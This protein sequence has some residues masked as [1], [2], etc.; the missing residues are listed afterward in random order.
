MVF[1]L[2]QKKRPLMPCTERRARLL[3]QRG[4]AV[5]HRFRPFTIRLKDRL[6][7]DS[8]LQPVVLKIDPGSQTTGM[9]IVREEETPEGKVHHVLHFSELRHK[10]DLVAERMRKRAAYRRRRRTHNLR[11]R[12]PRFN[13]RCRPVGWLTP[14][15]RSRVGNVLSWVKRYAQWVPMVRIDLEY[16]KFD[17][18][19]LQN[20]EISGVAYQQGELAGYEVR[21]YLL[22]KWGR[23][24][25]YC[26]AEGGAADRGPY[27]PEEPWRF[28]PGQQFG[29]GLP[30]LQ[31]SEGPTDGRRVW[32]SRGA[33]AGPGTAAG[34]RGGECGP[35]VY[36]ARVTCPGVYSDLL[37]RGPDEV[38]PDPVRAAENPCP[39]RP[40]CGRGGEGLWGPSAGSAD[41]WDR[42]RGPVSHECR[43]A[44]VPPGVSDALQ[45]GAGISDGRCGMGRGAA[46]EACWDVCRA[47]DGATEWFLSDWED[48]WHFLEILPIVAA[49]RWVRIR[50][51][52]RT[53]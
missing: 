47:G 31:L 36:P 52:K 43:C 40:V 42:T 22:E 30:S 48:R 51:E 17:T 4:R 32:P 28:R 16:T 10:G 12:P 24:C 44:W 25:A 19:K 39:G 33:G 3:L 41:P 15:M 37:E 49:Y 35:S 26:G 13:N 29:P 53:G 34:C 9:A 23:R 45:E 5:I 7:E 46:G 11:Y 21:E 14:C 20:P 6:L 27:S 1:V 38:E 50:A 2:D 8:M 18:Q